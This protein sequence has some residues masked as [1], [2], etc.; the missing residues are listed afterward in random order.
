MAGDFV[1]RFA[2][3]WAQP[4]PDRFE[5]LF[6]PDV[7]LA[8]P[9]GRPAVGVRAASASLARLFALMPDAR[10]EVLGWRGE[11]DTVFIE[12]RLAGTFGGKPLRWDLVDRITL[13]DG[14][15]AE[16]VAY[17]DPLPLIA[18][19]ARRPRGWRRLRSLVPGGTP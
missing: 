18:A 9:L 8:Q 6:Q 19:I 14:L 5:A 4:S 11:G 12:L 2:E 3:A 7:R 15:I 16:R 1:R 17:F 13:R 10:G